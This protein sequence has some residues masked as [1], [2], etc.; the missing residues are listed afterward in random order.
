MYL[1]ALLPFAPSPVFHSI[2]RTC[3]VRSCPWTTLLPSRTKAPQ[4]LFYLLLSYNYIKSSDLNAER[5]DPILSSLSL[6]RSQISNLF[7]SRVPCLGP[8]LVRVSL[9]PINACPYLSR[10]ACAAVTI[11][12]SFIFPSDRIRQ[13]IRRSSKSHPFE[14]TRPQSLADA[15]ASMSSPLLSAILD[16]CFSSTL[17]PSVD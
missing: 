13:P 5:I 11:S 8:T 3:I 4:L 14:V 9:Y 1:L 6:I 15:P 2:V 7:P 17:L 12:E 16:M 10:S